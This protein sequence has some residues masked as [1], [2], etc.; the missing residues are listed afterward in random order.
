MA[1]RSRPFSETGNKL[2]QDPEVAALYLEECLADGD[3]EL[4]KTALKKVA[5]ARLGGMSEL[6]K[7]T[8]LG[9]ESLYKALSDKG[10]PKL[11]TLTK[12]L[13]V[14]CGVGFLILTRL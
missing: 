2:L 3:I 5:D 9:R 14:G 12:V 6:A 10:N 4:F 8:N 13:D 7:R 1:R 11:E